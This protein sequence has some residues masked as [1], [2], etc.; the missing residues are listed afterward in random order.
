M[1]IASGALCVALV[2][3]CSLVGIGDGPIAQFRLIV[4]MLD[5]DGRSVSQQ[6]YPEDLAGLE[7][8]LVTAERTLRF[9]RANLR[10]DMSL[11]WLS[12][13]IDMP[14]K[15]TAELVVRLRHD[16][17]VVAADTVTWTLKPDTRW[18]VEVQRGEPRH[19]PYDPAFSVGGSATIKVWRAPIREDVAAYEGETL[20]MTLFGA[21]IGPCDREPEKC[22]PT[23]Q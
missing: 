19:F 7:A 5:E 14:L 17:E 13:T 3:A 6:E 21:D 18:S 4:P 23:T 8:E 20:T 16:G 15:G 12:Q 9:N 1:R 10:G 11:I 22:L 2:T